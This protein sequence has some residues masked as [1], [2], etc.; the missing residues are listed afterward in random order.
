MLATVLRILGALFLVYLVVVAFAWRFQEWV[1][2][3]APERPLP[4]PSAFGMP[5]GER[6]TVTTVDNVELQGWYL[7]P[8]PAPEHGSSAPGLIW[9]YG[10]FETVGAIGAI[11]RD[12]RPTGT[13]MLILDYRGYGKSGGKPTEEGLYRDAL[14]AWDFITSRPQIDGARVAV[15]G[16]S[17]GGAAALYL[18]TEQPVR[19]VVLDS[20]FSNG[21]EMAK[22]HYRFVPSGLV[23]LKLDNIARARK[24]EAP[25]L[26]FHGTADRVAPL[27]MG[28]AVA[29]AGR[30]EELVL[31]EGSGHND[32]YH[33]G[34]TMYREKLHAF[35]QKHLR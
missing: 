28:R 30:A 8:N 27:P 25:L 4:H 34:G 19:A 21:R 35:L 29:Q 1:V 31:L 3:P 33:V 13:G 18:A 5:E 20:P 14:A 7:P 22:K 24:L 15:Y 9:F 10:N 16:R 12:L 17:L 23:R 32:T 26:V 6:I 2:F 11:L